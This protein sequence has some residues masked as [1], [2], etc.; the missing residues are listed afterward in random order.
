M[1]NSGVREANLGKL[2]SSLL[3][4]NKWMPGSKC[5][6]RIFIQQQGCSRNQTL[7]QLWV[8]LLCTRSSCRAL[9]ERG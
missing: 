3:G 8:Q 1:P 4:M 5:R 6:W 9:E 7:L 2:C